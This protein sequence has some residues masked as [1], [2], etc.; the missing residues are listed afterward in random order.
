MILSALYL[1]LRSTSDHDFIDTFRATAYLYNPLPI[2][3][4]PIFRFQNTL[5][6]CALLFGSQTKRISP[7]PLDL[8]SAVRGVQ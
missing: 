1:N 8:L 6:V 4:V 2:Y 7:F 3:E 5:V